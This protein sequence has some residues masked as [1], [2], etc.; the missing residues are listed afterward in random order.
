MVPK[1]RRQSSEPPQSTAL[2]I[3]PYHL[4]K[5]RREERNET[6]AAL[7]DR[8]EL[9]DLETEGETSGHSSVLFLDQWSLVPSRLTPHQSMNCKGRIYC[10]TQL[11]QWEEREFGPVTEVREAEG[12]LEAEGLKIL[13][14]NASWVYTG[15]RAKVGL[16]GTV[17][18]SQ[19]MPLY[20]FTMPPKDMGKM[21]PMT[22]PYGTPPPDSPPSP[23]RGKDEEEDEEDVDVNME[24]Q[25]PVAQAFKALPVAGELPEAAPHLSETTEPQTT[26]PGG[27]QSSERRPKLYPH[28][29]LQPR[30]LQEI[31]LRHDLTDRPAAL[32]EIIRIPG[33]LTGNQQRQWIST[34]PHPR[35]TDNWFRYL[36]DSNDKGVCDEYMKLAFEFKHR[37]PDASL[38]PAA[39]L[40]L[41]TDA[42]GIG[43]DLSVAEQA[44]ITMTM[45][46]HVKPMRFKTWLQ[47][48]EFYE[49][50]GLHRR[51]A[52]H[53][54][55][56]LEPLRSGA[57][58]TYDLTDPRK[59]DSLPYWKVREE[60]EG[61]QMY[62]L[63]DSW[64][65]HMQRVLL[66]SAPGAMPKP[67][68]E[69]VKQL[70]SRIYLDAQGETWAYDDT[71]SRGGEP[72][73]YKDDGL[74]RLAA[75]PPILAEC[76]NL[77]CGSFR[78]ATEY[79]C[80]RCGAALAQARL[81]TMTW[82]QLSE[83]AH[84]RNG[85]FSSSCDRSH[86]PCLP[87]DP[88][89]ERVHR[90]TQE[91][92]Q[93]E[94]V[95]PPPSCPPS[96]PPSA[97]GSETS[98]SEDEG[99]SAGDERDPE[100]SSQENGGE[101]GAYP[102]FVEDTEYEEEDT[103]RPPGFDRMNVATEPVHATEPEEAVPRTE[104]GEG[105]LSEVPNPRQMA[106]IPARE[107]PCES[108]GDATEPSRPP[109][110]DDG[111]ARSRTPSG[112]PLLPEATRPTSESYQEAF[113][114]YPPNPD[115]PNGSTNAGGSGSQDPPV[116][117]QLS[118]AAVRPT[119]HT[120]E[121][122]PLDT[123]QALQMQM[124]Q[125]WRQAMQGMGEVVKEMQ[126]AK[127]HVRRQMARQAE[128][129]SELMTTQFEVF[130]QEMTARVEQVRSTRQELSEAG[131][132]ADAA[133]P[134][135]TQWMLPGDPN[136]RSSGRPESQNGGL[137]YEN[138]THSENRSTS[139]SVRN[140]AGMTEPAAR[141][142]QSEIEDPWDYPESEV[143][144]SGRGTP[145]PEDEVRSQPHSTAH[146]HSQTAPRSQTADRPPPQTSRASRSTSH[147]PPHTSR[148][149]QTTGGP[150]A[151]TYTT[152][153]T[154]PMPSGVPLSG[155]TRMAGGRVPAGSGTWAF[156]D[157]ALM[158]GMRGWV[159][160][161]P[162]IRL[163][164][165]ENEDTNYAL[166]E[167]NQ[168]SWV[169]QVITA[170]TDNTGMQMRTRAFWT[171]EVLS[172]WYRR[173]FD[174]RNKNNID[175]ITKMNFPN[176]L[177]NDSPET[178]ALGWQQFR[179]GFIAT[180]RECFRHGCRWEHILQKL[181]GH[182][183]SD[184]GR[185]S[186]RILSATQE[187]LQDVAFLSDDMARGGGYALLGA[188]IFIYRLDQSFVVKKGGDLH[189]LEWSKATFRLQG[190]DMFALRKR[191]GELYFKYSGVSAKEVHKTTHHLDT[192]NERMVLCLQNDPSDPVRG[193][194]DA[195]LYEELVEVATQ[196]VQR[197][198]QGRDALRPDE[199]VE[200][201]IPLRKAR[202]RANDV[203]GFRRG[204]SMTSEGDGKQASRTLRSRTNVEP[205]QREPRGQR[206]KR[207]TNMEVAAITDY[208]ES[209]SSVAAVN[210]APPPGRTRSLQPQRPHKDTVLP[211]HPQGPSTR[212]NP[213]PSSHS[214]E[215]PP[216]RYERRTEQGTDQR[217]QEWG[218]DIEHPAGSKGHPY[219]KE[220][221]A[222]DWNSTF[223][224]Y[225]KALHLA[226]KNRDL[227]QAMAR[228]M[229][230][231]RT[232]SAPAIDL[233]E[234]N[235]RPQGDRPAGWRKWPS[236][237]CAFCA[238]RPQNHA[239]LPPW[240][241]GVGRGDHPPMTCR[242]AKRWLAE[243]GDPETS[244][245]ARD[246]QSCLYIRPRR[247][248]QQLRD[249]RSGNA[250]R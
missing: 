56:Y 229:P 214:Q 227:R 18:Y 66:G 8:Q 245:V 32:D 82:W 92:A 89:L 98:E 50:L 57:V 123:P 69:L 127:K 164:E 217:T 189:R 236:G 121:Y 157:P 45:E 184:G 242:A 192:F 154:P 100:G 177:R 147:A 90:A 84:W 22:A 118:T 172:A 165:Q 195:T 216:Q 87:E 198:R 112:A 44:A 148:V 144:P 20:L 72:R 223:I 61:G 233:P 202:M 221:T 129:L 178:V 174:V 42:C 108:H 145:L 55:Q 159:D 34:T 173:V 169:I 30:A 25:I 183:C 54:V 208:G 96:P 231:D 14:G 41:L 24:G 151:Q 33:I 203:K 134:S 38:V 60:E 78:P 83:E 213:N 51:T 190:E 46:A 193:D 146:I 94:M 166:Q 120:P 116:E 143:P 5:E 194:T 67:R 181:L 31:T 249:D 58:H 155:M 135:E 204:D 196:K 125:E 7:A 220:W 167:S 188:D 226:S 152:R 124:R 230:Q 200:T 71:A 29:I 139:A 26:A 153:P 77:P 209:S 102:D 2:D 62:G 104:H 17:F 250:N 86:V 133:P 171:P 131:A 114:A 16:L 80:V 101:E 19:G 99:E 246:L 247:E 109:S 210:P 170:D 240:S 74:G 43:R 27:N 187:A 161:T 126:Q 163:Y 241:L 3:S 232:M 4:L 91:V 40:E 206:A 130:E 68:H 176:S 53:W 182:L 219:G 191:L 248:G 79:A 15:W 1:P 228:F 185:R 117:S 88:S 48:I 28:E 235:Q 9:G 47:A 138:E 39:R 12:S 111:V 35:R 238:F 64:G 106:E 207:N 113:Y 234:P 142:Q 6:A 93:R 95:G 128:H 239:T 140:G 168:A 149:P 119:P 162:I 201:A 215:P 197:G 49:R 122:R 212:G 115:D 211:G 73:W 23:P 244:H 224:N 137:P 70:A 76:P 186:P 59:Q 11:P 97:P 136:P 65:R 105:V 199:I 243:G 37:S 103:S 141:E 158:G 132:P 85:G 52:L 225:S 237:S 222:T 36:V 205:P 63:Q 21:A 81:I 160:D 218:R 179:P 150:R 75:L 107:H 156:P 175:T 180:L 110:I 10:P 13:L